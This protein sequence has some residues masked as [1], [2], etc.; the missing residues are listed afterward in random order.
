[1]YSR[2]Q[3]P[4]TDLEWGGKKSWDD[5]IDRHI[6]HDLDGRDWPQEGVVFRSSVPIPCTKMSVRA[7]HRPSEN[8]RMSNGKKKEKFVANGELDDDI[9]NPI[10]LVSVN[11]VHL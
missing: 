2:G 8:H 7:E 4:Y 9:A 11:L 1:M 5:A 6:P 10:H 3:V